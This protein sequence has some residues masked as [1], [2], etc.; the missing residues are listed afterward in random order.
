[1]FYI[2]FFVA[3]GYVIFI[4]CSP[5]TLVVGI[6]QRRKRKDVQIKDCCGH[7]KYSYHPP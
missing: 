6:V 1:M 7:R 5:V 4:G 2:H 3:S